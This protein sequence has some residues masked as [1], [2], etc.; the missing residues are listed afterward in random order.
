MYILMW[1]MKAPHITYTALGC[2]PGS[3]LG[4]WRGIRRMDGPRGA[5]TI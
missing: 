3:L 4:M 1:G 2:S 5:T